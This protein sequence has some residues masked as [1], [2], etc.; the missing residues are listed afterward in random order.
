MN[1]LKKNNKKC[2][3]ITI[4]VL[5]TMIAAN[6]VSAQRRSQEDEKTHLIKFE[7]IKGSSEEKDY[8]G[9]MPI[10]SWS[11]GGS[12]DNSTGRESY[13]DFHM[14]VGGS[15]D[16]LE[17]FKVF[18]EKKV[19]PTVTFVKLKYRGDEMRV[20]VP[21]IKYTFRDV[22]LTSFNIGG[23]NGSY[24]S[25]MSQV[26]LSFKSGSYE[27]FENGKSLGVVNFVV[28]PPIKDVKLCAA[29]TLNMTED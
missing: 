9:Y 29:T 28:P 13:Q 26:S 17:M 2:L 21:V 6:S 11:T 14:V 24:E 12:F 7:G 27:V 23:S 19:I 22:N 3:L 10:E 1:S 18:S 8:I 25:A 16:S 5:I 20:G 4:L 15:K